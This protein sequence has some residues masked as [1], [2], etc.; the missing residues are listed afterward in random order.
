MDKSSIEKLSD[1]K[2]FSIE[3]NIGAGKTTIINHLKTL[4]NDILLVE[5]PVSEWQNI[6]GENILE[7]KNLNMERWGYSFEAYVLISK[8]NTLIKAADSEKKIILIERC[9]LSD[10]AFFDVNVKN[11]LN[12]SMETEMFNNL[13]NFL[14]DNV[15]PKSSCIIYIDTPVDECINRI[16]RRGR[17]VEANI[18]KKYLM[19]LNDAFLDL[20]VKSN[21]PILRLDRNYDLKDGIH[22]VGLKLS[23]KKNFV[24]KNNLNLDS[25]SSGKEVIEKKKLNPNYNLILIDKKASND[26]YGNAKY[27]RKNTGNKLDKMVVMN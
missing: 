9:M 17:S 14:N 18:E 20:I 3:G 25:M 27:F 26:D 11:G 1:K 4:F 22:E 23:K 7:K 5:E 12:T 2:I 13:Y 15:Y 19:Q 10:K 24:K 8:L 21:V 16:I 6:N